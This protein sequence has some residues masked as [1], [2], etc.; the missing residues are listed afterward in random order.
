[1][2]IRVGRN[3]FINQ[4]CMLNDIGGIEIGDDAMI[5]PR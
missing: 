4:L 5:G 1:V 2:D 3:V